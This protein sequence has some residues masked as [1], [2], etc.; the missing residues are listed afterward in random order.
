MAALQAR[1]LSLFTLTCCLALFLSH[2]VHSAPSEPEHPGDD[3]SPEELAKYYSDL[4][5]YITF[6]S[7]PRYGKRSGKEP[8]AKAGEIAY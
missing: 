2:C 3:A 5:Q 7:R 6:V 4:W 1:W 8:W